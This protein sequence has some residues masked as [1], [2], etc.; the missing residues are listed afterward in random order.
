MEPG[1]NAI[2]QAGTETVEFSPNG[3]FQSSMEVAMR[4]VEA[5][6]SK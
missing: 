4:N 1:H 3:P 5:M 2:Y 6:R